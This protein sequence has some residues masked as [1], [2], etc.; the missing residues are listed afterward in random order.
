[1]ITQEWGLDGYFRWLQGLR[2]QYKARRDL[3]L[4]LLTTHFKVKKQVLE[5]MPG[6]WQL[7]Y[8]GYN[9]PSTVKGFFSS[10]EKVSGNHLVS[11]VPPTAGMFIWI[12]VHF[13]HHPSYAKR[14][15]QFQSGLTKSSP[16]H[17]MT[18]ELFIKLAKKLVLVVPGTFFS[19]N[20]SSPGSTPSKHVGYYRISFS[21][22]TVSSFFGTVK[23]T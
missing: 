8:K 14:L 1:M 10:E 23:L 15:Y 19:T 6:I 3:I 16:E 20:G 11:F 12:R 9:H 5:I 7:G 21:T 18:D 4:D 2:F 22:A 13:E 17:E